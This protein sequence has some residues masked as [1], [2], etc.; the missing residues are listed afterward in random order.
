M[1]NRFLCG[2]LAR[3]DVKVKRWNW[4][5]G[6]VVGY[7]PRLLIVAFEG[8]S[9]TTHGFLHRSHAAHTSGIAL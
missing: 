6:G 5:V 4:L 8:P 9:I 3:H 2:N 7:L 1:G